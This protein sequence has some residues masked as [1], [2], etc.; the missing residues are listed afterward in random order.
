MTYNPF[1]ALL[2][3]KAKEVEDKAKSGKAKRK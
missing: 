1:A 2:K 3:D